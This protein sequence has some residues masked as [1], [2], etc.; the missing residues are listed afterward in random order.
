LPYSLPLSRS[1]HPPGNTT[2]L[3]FYAKAG[4]TPDEIDPTRVA[5]ED[6]WEDLDENGEENHCDYRIMSKVLE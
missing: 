5:D 6:G 3:G 2:A 1:L 4:Y